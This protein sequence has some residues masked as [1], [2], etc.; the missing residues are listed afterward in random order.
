MYMCEVAIDCY[1]HG[2]CRQRFDMTS[3]AKVKTRKIVIRVTI[4]YSETTLVLK[5]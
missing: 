5:I 2:F 3:A 1:R 4:E